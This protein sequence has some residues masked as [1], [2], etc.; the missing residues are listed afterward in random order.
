MVVLLGG[1]HV[2]E[3]K[4]AVLAQPLHASAERSL[5]AMSYCCVKAPCVQQGYSDEPRS[6]CQWAVQRAPNCNFSRLPLPC[7]GWAHLEVQADAED[8]CTV[9][10]GNVNL[11]AG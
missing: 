3:S 7:S 4:R 10:K 8:H 2:V 9:Q 6:R 5:G 11:M 1:R